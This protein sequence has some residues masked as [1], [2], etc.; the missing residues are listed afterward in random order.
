MPVEQAVRPRTSTERY[1]AVAIALHWL[2]AAAIL[3]AWWIGWDAASLALSPRKLRLVSWHK[4]L[5]VSILA[6]SLVRLGWRLAHRPPPPVV[7]SP[8]QARL[9]SAVHRALYV[10][11]IA[12]PLLGWAYSGA[13]G[14]PVVF[15]ARIP[16]PAI[17]P[18]NELLAAVLG[19][20]HR[21]GA[22]TLVALAALHAAAALRHHFVLHDDVLRRMLPS[23]VRKRT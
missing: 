15:L 14:V 6:L 10:L 23:L 11:F 22:W 2:L 21:W 4:W 5:G 19:T 7:T 16:L 12:I 20:A 8:V 3:A 18:E 17:A 13:A 1:G 9:A